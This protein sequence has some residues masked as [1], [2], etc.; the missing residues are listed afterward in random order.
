MNH[1]ARHLIYGL[2]EDKKQLLILLVLVVVI[3]L[4]WGRLMLKQVPRM[5]VAT[6][7][8]KISPDVSSGGQVRAAGRFQVVY[9]DLPQTLNRDLFTVDLALYQ[10][11]EHPLPDVVQPEKLNPKLPDGSEHKG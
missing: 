6:P 9:V 7:S 10:C 3:P 1:Y 8:T 5:A 2:T 4:L 11:V